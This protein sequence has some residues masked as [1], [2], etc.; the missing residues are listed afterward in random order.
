M[1]FRVTFKSLNLGVVLLVLLS[2]MLVA[3]G[4]SA[5]NTPG[6]AQTTTAGSSG[7]ASTTAA[8]AGAAN[9]GAT[10]DLNLWMLPLATQA[11]PPPS[12]WEGYKAI[13]DQLNI[14]LNLTLLPVGSEGETKVNAAAAANSLPDLF[15]PP[16]QNNDLFLKWQQQG[17]LAPVESLLPLMPNRTKLFYSDPNV[18]KLVTINGKQYALQA[19]AQLT[20]RNGLVIRKDWLDKLGLK[21]PT[22]LDEF[23]EVAKAFTEKDP[24]G[25]GKNDT[26]GFGALINGITDVGWLWTNFEFIFGAYGLPGIW[27]YQNFGLNVRDPNYEKGVEFIKK[28]NDAKVIDPDWPTMKNDDFDA[29]WKQ[30][31]YGMFVYDFA[32]IYSKPN[33]TVFDNAFPNAELVPLAPPKGPDG[34][35]SMSSYTNTGIRLLVSKKAIDAGKGPAI[36]KFLEWAASTDGGYYLLS[37]GKEGVNYK[38]DAQGNITTDGVSAPWTDPSVTKYLQMR[39]IASNGNPQEL[40]ARY[41]SYTTKAGRTIDPYQ[42]YNTFKSYPNNDRTADLMIKASP[43]QVDINRYVSE[44]L[45]Q[46]IL[47]QKPLNDGTWKEFVNGLNGLGVADWETSAKKNL[48]DSGYLK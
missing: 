42:V 48:Q 7:N 14:N 46:F 2:M 17:L 44:N 43:N 3:C 27:N 36:A 34:K 10:T 29:R 8:G 38:K 35:S 28:L 13:K 26:Y 22:T 9:S 37:F 5:T 11:G 47:G 33:Y 18:N 31:K 40:K 25:N 4:D 32:G 19:P 20:T 15:Q 23:F 1:K 16:T 21:A 39:N 12:D 24:D 6:A 30:G 41:P 45:V